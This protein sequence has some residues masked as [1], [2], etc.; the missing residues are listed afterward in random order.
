MRERKR[1]E[2]NTSDLESYQN[3]VV[4]DLNETT[5][6]PNTQTN[7]NTQVCQVCGV[8]LKI[9]AN[10]VNMNEHTYRQLSGTYAGKD[11]YKDEFDST[12]PL[13][14]ADME[15]S[16]TA[17]N[18]TSN[19]IEQSSHTNGDEDV[20]EEED[21][22]YLSSSNMK[23]FEPLYRKS[24]AP[25][26]FPAST[27]N[28]AIAEST[29]NNHSSSNN[30][31]LMPGWSA[32]INQT[33]ALFDMMS[34]NTNI[35]HPLCEECADQLV[36]QL[37]TQCK[38]VEK[39]YMEYQTLIA[40]L[41]QQLS[42]ENELDQLEDE[43]KQ[44][45]LEEN[46][47]VARIDSLEKE[48]QKLQQ[49]KTEKTAEEMALLQQEQA[50]LLEYSNFKRQL[51]KLEEKQE[52]LDNQ[53][54]NTKFHFKRLVSVNV[55]NAAFHIWHSG[56]FGTI[57]F[58]RLGTLPDIPVEW[59]EINAGL[60]QANLLLYCL[61]NKMK[62]EFKRYRLVPNGSYSYIQVIENTQDSKAGEE[63]NMYR[64][65]GYKYLFDWDKK[66]EKGMC[67]FLDCLKQL[68]AKISSLDTE[69]SL[70]YKINQHKLEDKNGSIYS[71]KCQLNS[72]EEWTKALKYMLTNLKWTLAW[73][74]SN[75]SF[76]M[77]AS[78]N[79]ANSPNS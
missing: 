23:T 27:V 38:Q 28:F 12:L 60:G 78:S 22:V 66:F 21:E 19:R 52:S 77:P 5:K 4:K 53:L 32:R 24:I 63:L 26:L 20:V 70:P 41:N 31:D 51:M 59:E 69:F 71:I 17:L 30:N 76:S 9:D 3:I 10:I 40:R 73:V 58:F 49:E 25:Y 61:A 33:S 42:N 50:Y 44:L 47:L 57:N 16:V 35:D 64:I 14:D 18:I 68:E 8:L 74:T 43:L 54:K 1:D 48:E 56:P 29:S 62:F 11:T 7:V 55:L 39:E 67:A 6:K 72:F 15:L 45:E 2:M 46:T 34:S 13:V 65:K 36:N 79:S 75:D 37:D